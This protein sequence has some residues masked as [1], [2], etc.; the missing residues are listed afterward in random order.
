VLAVREFRVL[1]V[2]FGVFMIGETV[3][4]LALAVLLYERTGSV[5][6]AALAYV[7][8][9]LPHAVGGVLLLALADRWRPQAL[10]IGYDLLRLAV[11]ALLAVGVRRSTGCC[12]ATGGS[13]GCCWSTGCPGRC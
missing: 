8:G 3:K 12:F 7:V 13:E 1:F 9:F 10:M 6:L 11:V 2:S 5:L 4:M